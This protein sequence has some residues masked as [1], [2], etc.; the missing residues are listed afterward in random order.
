VLGGDERAIEQL[1][2][3]DLVALFASE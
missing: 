2:A 1:G 3:A